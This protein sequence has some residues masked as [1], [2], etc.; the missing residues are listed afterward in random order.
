M[1]E[2]DPRPAVMA[3]IDIDIIGDLEIEHL[4]PEFLC[5]PE[6]RER[7]AHGFGDGINAV[8]HMP[9]IGI[10]AIARVARMRINHAV[11]DQTGCGDA[12]ETAVLMNDRRDRVRPGDGRKLQPRAHR[13]L[14]CQFL[15]EFFR[16]AG[17][18]HD[19]V[20]AVGHRRLAPH[21]VNRP[22]RGFLGDLQTQRRNPAVVEQKRS[23][24]VVTVVGIV[25]DENERKGGAR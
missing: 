19:R 3:L 25:V 18:I 6:Q 13:H 1:G 10:V 4:G 17:A 5:E 20:R 11:D 9:A 2:G 15:G 22:R 14:P 21:I 12:L 23:D 8:A 24:A 16:Q 7:G